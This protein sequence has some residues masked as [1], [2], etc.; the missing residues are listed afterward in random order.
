MDHPSKRR[1]LTPSPPPISSPAETS[2]DE[3]AAGS[4]HDQERRRVSLNVYPPKRPYQRSRS[5]SSSESPDELAMDA[6]DY[7][8]E[9]NRRRGSSPWA[10]GS[11]GSR[12]GGG[13]SGDESEG[14]RGDEE[15]AERD[16]DNDHDKIEMNGDL[17]GMDTGMGEGYEDRSPTPVPP[18]PPP[19]PD[20]VDYREK[21][22]LRGHLR[23]VSAVRFSPDAGMI[24]SGGTF[25]LMLKGYGTNGCRGGRRNQGLG[26]IYGEINTHIRRTSRGSIDNLMGP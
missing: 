22:L 17:D 19:K 4:D 8:R 23:G 10:R 16:H 13:R 7:W 24:A 20:S 1:R 12:G 6:D 26:Y 14:E 3:L 18:P 21:F 9:R 5:F 11:R 25:L 15:G 2:S